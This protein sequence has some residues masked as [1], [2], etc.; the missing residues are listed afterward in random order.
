MSVAILLLVIFAIAPLAR[1]GSM[2]YYS[3]PGVENPVTY[4]FTA[5][6]TGD[7]TAYFAGS[8]AWNINKI[9]MV[10]LTQGGSVN[11]ASFVF[12]NL[13]TAGSGDYT[14]IGTSVNL[15]FANQGD[16]LLFVMATY[17]GIDW[18]NVYSDP[19]MN[20]NFDGGH[21]HIYAVPYSANS[22]PSLTLSGLY[23]GFEDTP[24]LISDYNYLD[25][26]VILTNVDVT[27]VAEPAT[28]FLFGAGLA[29]IAGLR[30]RRKK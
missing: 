17:N 19:A 11:A 21:N 5:S 10:N 28:M 24:N 16:V 27:P 15:G 30:I 4:L 8:D 20:V 25:E 6:E 12:T 7:I 3:N 18:Q 14:S 26:S 22:I 29:G 9:A 23:I 1:A 2:P 13:K